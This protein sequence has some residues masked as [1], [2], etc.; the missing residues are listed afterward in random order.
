MI[1]QPIVVGWTTFRR[2][3]L[4]YFSKS[5]DTFRTNRETTPE[6]FHDEVLSDHITTDRC[7]SPGQRPAI[8][9]DDRGWHIRSRPEVVRLLGPTF[10]RA[11]AIAALD[12][13]SRVK[14]AERGFSGCLLTNHCQPLFLLRSSRAHRAAGARP[15]TTSQDRNDDDV[16]SHSWADSGYIAGVPTPECERTVT[17]KL[18]PHRAPAVRRVGVPIAVALLLIG[19]LASQTRYLPAGSVPSVG[20]AFAADAYVD[21]I[22]HGRVVPTTESK[23]VDVGELLAALEMDPEAAQVTYG[24]VSSSGS[25]SYLIRGRGEARLNDVGLLIVSDPDLPAGTTLSLATS[26]N[27]GTSLRDA[28]GFISVNDFETQLDYANVATA[29]NSRAQ[30]QTFP[31]GAEQYNGVT[32]DFIGA[33]TIIVPTALSVMAVALNIP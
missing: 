27:T 26:P 7:E 14:R 33:V 11:C 19:F 20:A 3:N 2:A 22:W 23:S 13:P 21:E 28:L 4:D 29:L 5:V 6:G 1:T 12:G 15:A 31:D 25:F 16:E 24:H 17:T 30:A 10:D 8:T 32:I 18:R 9:V